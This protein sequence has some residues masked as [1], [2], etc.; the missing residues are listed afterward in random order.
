MKVACCSVKFYLHGNRSLKGKRQVLRAMKDRL[1]N[2]FNVS[3][4][5]VGHQDEWQNLHLGIV[6]VSPDAKYLDG[7]MN[8][9]VDFLDNLHLA[10]MT[11]H[12][13]ELIHF[14]QDSL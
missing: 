12:E 2:K 7:L 5:E 11:G 10:E 6:A 14:G 1:K 8:Q 3:V 4:A 13:F 9:V